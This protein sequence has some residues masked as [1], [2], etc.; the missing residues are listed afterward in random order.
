MIFAFHRHCSC[1]PFLVF[2]SSIYLSFCSFLLLFFISFPNIYLLSYSMRLSSFRSFC[3]LFITL[4][5]LSL[6]ISLYSL[7]HSTSFPCVLF[8]N[9]FP[10]LFLFLSISSCLRHFFP[11]YFMSLPHSFSHPHRLTS[12]LI[13]IHLAVFT[14]C[15]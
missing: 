3:H 11:R 12:T 14:S 6:F 5:H 1:L 13:D 15:L 4:F 7:S 10:I 2:S 8:V 9:L